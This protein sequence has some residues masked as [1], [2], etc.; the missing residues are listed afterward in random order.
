M[1]DKTD[2]EQPSHTLSVA[3]TGSGGSGVVTAGEML[4]IAVANAGF[5][6]LMGRSAGPQIRGGESAVML[7]TG[8]GPV[9][10]LDDRFDILIALDWLNV[11]R[12]AEEIPLTRDSLI[13][14]DPD[15]GEEIGRAS[16]RERV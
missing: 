11:S 3:I 5:Y 4:L 6:G 13:I 12:F 1:S 7:R 10:C 2:L 9:D 14:C 16:C 8:V 15:A